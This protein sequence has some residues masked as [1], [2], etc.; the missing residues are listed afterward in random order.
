VSAP[1]TPELKAGSV[2]ITE[3]HNFRLAVTVTSVTVT[4]I[5]LS[6]F[7]T[8]WS[9]VS[10]WG[11]SDTFAH[12]FL[13]FPFS[14][15][16]IWSQRRRLSTVRIQPNLSALVILG[17]I[18]LGWLMATLASAQVVAQF[19]LIAMIPASVWV[20]LG[21]RMIRE[22]AFPLA[23]LLLAVPFG[24]ALIPPLINFTAD[25]TVGALQLT[26]IPV[27]REGSFFTIPSGNWSVVE[28]CSGLRYLIASFTLG[29][30]YA[31]LTYRS[32][33]RRLIFIAL[34]VIVPV[35]ANGIRAYLIVMTGH[36]S[37]MRLA[38]GI[39]HLIYGW[40]FFGVVMLLLFWVGTFWREDQ[41]A[42][43]RIPG[44]RAM[45][46]NDS[47]SRVP[48]KNLAFATVAAITAAVVWP[49]YAVYLDNG[50][51]SNVTAPKLDIAGIPEKWGIS[52]DEMSE[53]RPYYTGA[54]TQFK[55]YYRSSQSS[56]S[57]GRTVGLFITYYRNQQQSGELI[58]SQ[59]LLTPED[60]P[61]DGPRWRDVRHDVRSINFGLGEQAINQ[62]LIQSSST[63]LLVWR[64]YWLG[65]ETTASPY[66]AK[67]ILAKNKLLGRP[68]DGAEIIFVTTYD[69]AFEEAVPTLESFGRD[70]MPSIKTGLTN[71]VGA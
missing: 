52:G 6:Y 69:Q 19:F 25:F 18:G 57:P 3:Q 45:D 66:V 32:L 27:Y 59:N 65:D 47:P 9:M 63:N 60:D 43:H 11:R 24:E 67:L 39:D 30:L 21:N 71:A 46:L 34:S 4:V 31:Y 70:M 1:T 40:V 37:D 26:G 23:Y 2:P 51:A 12:G 55:Q 42:H 56:E 10:I 62:N 54:T 5:L 64:I 13:I 14:A 58:N 68:D 28:A 48:L 36:L 15:Y 16:L 41:S 8:T 49:G 22:L 50:F 17:I 38:V 29:T 61:S 33:T 35:L 20:I 53:W 7:Q 44:N